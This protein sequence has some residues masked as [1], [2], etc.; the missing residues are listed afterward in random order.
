M[1]RILIGIVLL[2]FFGWL[3]VGQTIMSSP[4][5]PN[6]AT[7]QMIP[8]NNHGTIVYITSL[9]R[10]LNVGMPV[11]YILLSALVYRM[12]KRSK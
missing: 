4:V 10:Y 3:Y 8:Y 5:Q 9:Q 6:L 1:R 11:A 2:M 7:G 12:T